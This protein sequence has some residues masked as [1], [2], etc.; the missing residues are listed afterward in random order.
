MIASLALATLAVAASCVVP[1]VPIWP[2]MLLEHF[3]LQY[4]AVGVPVVA[5]AAALR[6]RGYFDVA[7]IATLINLLPIA[8]DLGA[9]PRLASGTPIR[10]LVLN[11][12]TSSTSFEQVRRLIADEQ[13]DL[14]GLLEVDQ[15]WLDAL[16]PTVADY[17]GRIEVPR[18]DNFGVALYARG[19]VHG[20]AEE[21]GSPLPSVVADVEIGTARL[22][23]IVTHPLPPISS[24]AVRQQEA[25]LDAIAGRARVA[26][27]VLLMGDLNA[28]PWS[29]PFLRLLRRSGL[30]D[31]RAGFGVQASFPASSWLLRIP[32]D[33]L[34]ASCSVGVRDRR[35]GRDVGSDHLPVIVDLIVPTAR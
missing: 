6:L 24:A 14:I 23:A 4:V 11:V 15:R 28:T 20:A 27:P 7:A 22:R 25:Q 1:L 19:R 26:T 10:V 8:A 35:I 5:L 32:I 9:S 12:L 33:H 17:P 29:R 18:P 21:I 34:L 30:C 13:P 3:R 2:C 31:S 16:A